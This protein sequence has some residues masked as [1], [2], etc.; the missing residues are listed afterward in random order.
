[1]TNENLTDDERREIALKR[2]KEL[3][4][5][6]TATDV[7][8]EKLTEEQEEWL[9]KKLPNDPFKQ[10][11]DSVLNIS[12]ND[13][14]T[15]LVEKYQN[16]Y[17]VVNEL[18]PEL[19]TPL[20]FALSIKTILN[21]KNC[22]LPFAGIL[23][24]PPSSSKTVIVELFR[25][26]KNSYYTDN[27]TPRTF[28]SH[29]AGIKEEELKKI[30]MLP[31]IKDKYFLCSELSPTF[32]K[33]EDELNEIIGIITRILD[34]QGLTTNT[35]A[36]GQ[37]SYEGEYM[38]TWLGAAVDIPYRAHKLMAS[39]GPKLY[40][41][42]L[43]RTNKTENELVAA[44]DKDDFMTKVNRI[45]NVL[46]DYL[47]WFDRCPVSETD[48]KAI[49]ENNLVKIKW[50]S[51]K[52]DEYAKHIIARI[53]LLLAH[54]RGVVPTW[55]THGTQGHNYAYATARIE[56]P[57]RAAT[58]LSNLARG[59]ALSQGRTWITIED[60][61]LPIKVV[62]STASIDR[63]NIFRLLIAHNGILTTNIINESLNTTY[64]TS[65]RIMA[66][67]KAV[68][69]VDMKE[70][71]TETEEKE[72][73]L[74]QEFD[75]FLTDEF[76]ELL[77]GFEPSDN[78]E[79]VKVFCKKFNI[80]LEEKTP[81]CNT[82][83]EPEPIRAKIY[84]CYECKK[85]NHGTVIYQTESESEYQKHWITSGHK[86]PCYPGIADLERYGWERQDKPWEI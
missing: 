29:Y 79:Y 7:E 45:R 11:I 43:P 20:D 40:F 55:E 44:M 63:T 1:M 6:P 36:C 4:E 32:M 39:I 70:T 82:I 73:R 69:L 78:S 52:N 38:F 62:L 56:D 68:E 12:Y 3:S 34:G 80:S 81:P 51:E 18:I 35:G 23:L 16:L 27:F 60:L 84:N 42:R 72:I 10:E 54:L 26:W 33:K 15:M 8:V 86:G 30:D 14:N 9:N 22:T 2:L 53:G 49:R 64:H 75:W 46:L 59:H 48:D 50:N 57:Q 47:Q 76:N 31:K 28:V 24:G 77:Q 5:N 85:I 83:I 61:P 37:R 66:E 41:L 13:W 17:K 65:H 21:I 58:Q 19:W 71:E 74:K 25:K 67:L